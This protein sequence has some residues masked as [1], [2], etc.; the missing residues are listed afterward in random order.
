MELGSLF[1]MFEKDLLRELI[2]D[3]V[4]DTMRDVVKT[5]RDAIKSLD[6]A[7]NPLAQLFAFL[8]SVGGG[9]GGNNGGD[10]GQIFSGSTSRAMGGPVR[11]GQLV[12]WQENGAEYFVS[13]TDGRVLT[14]QQLAGGGPGVTQEN[15][16]HIN[17]NDVAAMRRELRAAL[18]ERD[19]RLMRRLQYG[20]GVLAGG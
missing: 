6:G 20:R 9:G 2:A 10:I 17:G 11:G 14:Q 13:D 12:R 8:G 5:I 16:F 15:H 19:S 3:P 7:A 4:R 1:K 18:D